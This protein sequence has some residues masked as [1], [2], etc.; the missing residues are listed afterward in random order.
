M[1]NLTV[2]AHYIEN[3]IF[4]RPIGVSGAFRGPTP[5]F[6][7]QQADGLFFGF[8]YSW[9]KEWSKQLSGTFGINYLWSRNIE[10]NEPLIH[11]PPISTNYQLQWK[12][13]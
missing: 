7:Y 3:Y 8:D 13:R 1:H 6:I 11:Q 4:D 10:D 9:Q 2:F 5:A 12:K